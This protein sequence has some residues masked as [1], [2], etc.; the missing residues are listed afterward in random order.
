M[1]IKL[2]VVPSLLL[3]ALVGCS[4]AVLPTS[5]DAAARAVEIVGSGEAGVATQ[6][7][8][9]G[10]DVWEVPVSMPNGAELEVLLFVD[11]GELFEIKDVVGPFDYELD[12]LP[13][14]TT[15][16]EA[17]AR[18]LEL[19]PGTIEAWEV[20]LRSDV[21]R[22]FYEFYIRDDGGQLYELKHWAD[23]GELLAFE[24]VDMMD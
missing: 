5:D 1:R 15:Y 21:D 7:V 18:A 22:Y 6:T 11:T 4:N 23:D 3:S 9:D 8:D 17:R 13:G 14:M 20:K 19:N 24:A 2:L 12:P 16:G 10:F